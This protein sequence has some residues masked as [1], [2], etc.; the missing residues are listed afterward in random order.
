MFELYTM[1]CIWWINNVM[2]N[3]VSFQFS[4]GSSCIVLIYQFRQCRM[5]HTKL[6]CII[7]STTFKFYKFIHL[8]LN[9]WVFEQMLNLHTWSFRSSKTKEI[10][11]LLRSMKWKI[12]KSCGYLP[13]HWLLMDASPTHYYIVPRWNS[14]FLSNGGMYHCIM[15]AIPSS[16]C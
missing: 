4:N 16:I 8:V 12:E 13:P 6:Q 7:T 15:C 2:L 14:S 5:S 9:L 10:K 1:Q 11:S 3:F